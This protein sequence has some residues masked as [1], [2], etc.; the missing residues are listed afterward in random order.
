MY[1][2]Q[3]KVDI[4][5]MSSLT[6]EQRKMIEEKRKAAQAKLALKFAQKSIPQPVKINNNQCTSSTTGQPSPSR[7]TVHINY[8]S[9]TSNSKSKPVSGHCELI[10]KDRFTVHVGYHKQMIDV[11][12]TILSKSYGK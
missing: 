11:F 5:K 4:F 8:S 10:S 12:K 1:F 9:A 3:F 7:K 2:N 6:D